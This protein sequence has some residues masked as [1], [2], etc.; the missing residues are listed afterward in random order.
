MN[1]I[2]KVTLFLMMLCRFSTAQVTITGNIANEN[3]QSLSSVVVCIRQGNSLIGTTMSDSTGHYRFQ[4]IVKGAYHLLISHHS[5]RDSIIQLHLLAD[6][7]INLQLVNEKM[8]QQVVVTGK[9]PLIQMEID[10]LRFNVTGTELVVGNNVW[11]VIEK[12]P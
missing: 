8:L 7:V 10:R 9:K 5:Y 2:L 4:N 6:T 1:K 3:R 11:D 12:T